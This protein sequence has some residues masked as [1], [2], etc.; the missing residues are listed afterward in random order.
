MTRSSDRRQTTHH[1][2]QRPLAKLLFVPYGVGYHLAHH[3][4]SGVPFRNLERLHKEL[5]RSG[6]LDGASVWPSYP[7]LWK[8]L[9]KD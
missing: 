7:A 1:V 3:V 4:D 5:A 8:A 2:E 9:L 6:Y